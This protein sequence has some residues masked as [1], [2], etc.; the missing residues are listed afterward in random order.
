MILLFATSL[1]LLIPGAFSVTAQPAAQKAAPTSIQKASPSGSFDLQLG[2][3]DLK[4]GKGRWQSV[5]RDGQRL[6]RQTDASNYDLASFADAMLTGRYRL[7]VEIRHEQGCGAGF[8]FHSE[9]PEGPWHGEMIRFETPKTMLQ[10]YF[11]RGEFVCREVVQLPTAI[12]PRAWNRLTLAIDGEARRVTIEVNGE[13]VAKDLKLSYS[14]GHAGLQSSQSIAE[15]RKFGAAGE[16]AP[17]PGLAWPRQLAQLENGGLLVHSP[18]LQR[19]WK[20]DGS[21]ARPQLHEAKTAFE[22]M[23]TGIEGYEILPGQVVSGGNT[24]SAR[25]ASG[26]HT[27]FD[28]VAVFG[29]EGR[30]WSLDVAGARLVEV[31][32]GGGGDLEVEFPSPGVARV[33]LDAGGKVSFEK[34]LLDLE[35]GSRHEVELPQRYRTLPP[36]TWTTKVAFQTP[37]EEGLHRAR[38]IRVLAVICG[39]VFDNVIERDDDWPAAE[40][41]RIRKELEV[42]REWYW[43]QSGFRLLLDIEY[44]HEERALDAAGLTVE[45]QPYGRVRPELIH[46]WAEEAGHDISRYQSVLI[47][48]A[49][50]RKAPGASR[51]RMVGTGGGLTLGAYGKSYGQSWWFVPEQHGYNAWLLCHEFH[52][53]LDALF[54]LS[55]HP[56]YWYNHFSPTIGTSANFGEHWDGNAYLL[57]EWPDWQWDA[58]KYGEELLLKDADGDAFP[59]D[60]PDTPMDEKR[61]GSSPASADSDKDGVDDRAEI[62]MRHTVDHSGFETWIPGHPQPDPNKADSDGDGKRDGE[63]PLPLYAYEPQLAAGKWTVLSQAKSEYLRAPVEFA[64]RARQLDAGYAL[65]LRVRGL[66]AKDRTELRFLLDLG[67][68]G[69]FTGCDNA[70]L[71]YR[72]FDLAVR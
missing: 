21:E 38:R 10:G 68:D 7:S 41:E 30:V 9:K 29:W 31:P 61:F 28:P 51:Y 17:K 69:W 63:D 14:C 5:Q 19:S 58:L 24:F 25:E 57:R 54:D 18:A 43:V 60:A 40:Y 13:T 49:Y 34:T 12:D 8:L 59:D 71:L 47:I 15:F 35:P 36:Q 72:P 23:P 46:G 20:I 66:E 26:T 11:V 70:E 48:Q 22:A 27:P 45:N 33:T 42:C 4:P 16:H 50:R 3:Q 32:R 62:R 64:V 53:Q 1:S 6:H 56:E 37:P 44:L 67:A 52:H 65:D 39:N 2:R 55:G